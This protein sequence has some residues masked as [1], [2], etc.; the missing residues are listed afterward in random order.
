[1]WRTTTE[2]YR[3]IDT[4]P[5]AE[6]SAEM[7]SELKKWGI[8]DV[9]QLDFSFNVLNG[10]GAPTVHFPAQEEGDSA[11]VPIPA[12]AYIEGDHGY[13]GC[14]ADEDCHM[15][16]FDF[17]ANRLYELYQAHKNGSTWDGYLALWKLDKAY[18][19]SNRGQGCTSAD[20]VGLPIAP[21][22]IG[23]KET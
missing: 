1:I 11:D 5:I 2:W 8:N 22:L 9:F 4:A 23:Y 13:D 6:H 7:I 18:P 3:P 21:G 14:P 16:I 17:G 19:P 15:I 12:Q 10:Q 20:A